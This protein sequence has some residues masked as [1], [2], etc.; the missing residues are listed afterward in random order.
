MVFLCI[1]QS[2][3]VSESFSQLP[4]MFELVVSRDLVYKIMHGLVR[5]SVLNVAVVLICKTTC[6]DH[7]MRNAGSVLSSYSGLLG[8]R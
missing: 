8:I 1:R 2:N 5:A 7:F 6:Q 4:Y 3:G